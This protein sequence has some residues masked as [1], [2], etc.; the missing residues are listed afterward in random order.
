MRTN[1]IE[2]VR[3]TLARIYAKP[4]LT[5]VP[6]VALLDAALN[7]CPVNNVGLCYRRY[8]AD[9]QMEF[10]ESGYFL[11]LMP[12]RGSGELSI[13]ETTIELAE[14]A[15]VV[16]SADVGW[17]LRCTADYEH[18]VVKHDDQALTRKLAVM[19]GTAVGRRLQIDARQDPT[20]PQARIMTRYVRSLADTL[21]TADPKTPLPA[22]WAAQTEQLL[23]TMLLCCTPHNYSHLLDGEVPDAAARE[24]RR[25]E[26]YIEANWRQPVTLEDVAEATGVSTLCL[27]RSFRKVRGCSPMEFLA[28]IRSRNGGTD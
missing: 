17:R 4:V 1:S 16:V 26:D 18:L 7:Y 23:M 11:N 5:P 19:T 6:G 9:V 8:G 3:E 2:E 20:R 12:I 28:Q 25:V 15:A 22:W 27:Y 14:G 13:G 10:P 24:V 21:S